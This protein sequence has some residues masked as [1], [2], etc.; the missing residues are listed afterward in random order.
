MNKKLLDLI[1]KK[2][3][4][5]ADAINN[6]KLRTLGIYFTELGIKHLIENIMEEIKNE[7]SR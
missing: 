6:E 5:L 3:F 7:Y 1:E 2:M 4:D